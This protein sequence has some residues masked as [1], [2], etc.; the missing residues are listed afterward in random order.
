MGFYAP[1]QVRVDLNVQEHVEMGRLE[2]LS[3]AELL[4]SLMLGGQRPGDTDWEA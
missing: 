2:R 3:D 4:R 1:G